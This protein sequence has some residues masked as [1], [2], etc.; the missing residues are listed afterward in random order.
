MT[1]DLHFIRKRFNV[2][3]IE[4]SKTITENIKILDCHFYMVGNFLIDAHSRL[5]K[6]VIAMVLNFHDNR[7]LEQQIFIRNVT[8]NKILISSM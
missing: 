2:Y 6:K 4:H 1:D 7:Q 5:Q 3:Y 8:V